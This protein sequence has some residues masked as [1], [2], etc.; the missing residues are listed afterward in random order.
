MLK[1]SKITGER[2]EKRILTFLKQPIPSRCQYLVKQS[3]AY[4]NLKNFEEDGWAKFNWAE[5]SDWNQWEAEI[6]R[7][8]EKGNVYD[9]LLISTSELFHSKFWQ[10]FNESEKCFY[11]TL[12]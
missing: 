10:N 8:L 4:L 11:K 3:D 7:S 6:E 5:E 12:I 2:I 1:V 9:P